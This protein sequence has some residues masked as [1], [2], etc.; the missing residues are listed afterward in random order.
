MVASCDRTSLSSLNV[1]KMGT[2]RL[3]FGKKSTAKKSTAK[4][5]T[6][7]Q[8]NAT[9]AK[10]PAKKT[11]AK[12]RKGASEA[13]PHYPGAH[14]GLASQM[15]E[16]DQ[17]FQVQGGGMMVLSGGG[18]GYIVIPTGEEQ[19]TPQYLLAN[20]ALEEQLN[21]LEDLFHEGAEEG[22]EGA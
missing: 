3:H 11:A 20:P 19:I 22:A 9:A 5:A 14:M 7:V 10:K 2:H 4:K 8:K 15:S 17:I 1:L 12:N 16:G 13:H 18:G 21:N 6:V